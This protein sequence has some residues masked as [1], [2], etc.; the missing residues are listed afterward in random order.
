M[1]GHPHED[2]RLVTIAEFEHD[3]EAEMARIALEE[4][5]IECSVVG[6]D[7]MAN[8]PPIEPIKIEVQV[9]ERDAERAGQV[10][11]DAMTSAGDEGEDMD[12]ESDD[13]EPED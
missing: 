2:E 5:G 13:L 8:M 4:A 10:V 11:A 6:G 3:F 9:F 12:A 1:A 7:L